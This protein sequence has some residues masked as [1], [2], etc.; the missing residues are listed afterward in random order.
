M[1]AAGGGGGAGGRM[2]GVLLALITAGSGLARAA[3]VTFLL[4][5][6]YW[7]S[8]EF[9]SDKTTS[10]VSYSPSK[11]LPSV[12]VCQARE[13]TPSTS[14]V[15]DPLWPDNG[16]LRD[17]LATWAPALTSVITDVTVA[18]EDG[19]GTPI[20][21]HGEHVPT[22]V[23]LPGQQLSEIVCFTVEVGCC[24]GGAGPAA[25]ERLE[26]RGLRL[27]GFTG[28]WLV[29]HFVPLLHSHV[30]YADA[31]Q[32][33][34]ELVKVFWPPERVRSMALSVTWH[35]L[36][37]LDRP[38]RRC[39]PNAGRRHCLERGRL[40]AAA[41]AAG[42]LPHF[43]TPPTEAEAELPDCQSQESYLQFVARFQLPVTGACPRACSQMVPEI[44]QL[45]TRDPKGLQVSAEV[46]TRVG[47]AARRAR[48][49]AGPCS[50]TRA[51]PAGSR[52]T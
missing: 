24:S 19:N 20:A 3:C 29:V 39:A 22:V 8:E 37:Y 6:F 7:K 25:F 21:L 16:T 36:R 45:T 17:Y 49:G 1:M 43:V 41:A 50:A 4:L 35:H 11:R 23:L 26:L 52:R 38:R 5:L 42:C 18:A 28:P 12:S 47:G 51:P 15:D 46:S 32:K 40:R 13:R 9:F 33:K 48:D 34:T 31:K 10:L 2:P 14:P 27:P 30:I 44:V